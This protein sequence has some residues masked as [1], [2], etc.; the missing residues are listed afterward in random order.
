[1]QAIESW[2]RDLGFSEEL[3]LIC[4][5]LRLQSYKSIAVG[6]IFQ[7]LNQTDS[8]EILSEWTEHGLCQRLTQLSRAYHQ[9]EGIQNSYPALL[10]HANVKNQF[11]GQ[12][13]E[14]YLLAMIT[15]PLTFVQ[16]QKKQFW[17]R[18]LRLWVFI[19]ALL[20]GQQ[21]HSYLDKNLRIVARY[22]LIRPSYDINRWDVIDQLQQA[23]HAKLQGIQSDFD[24]FSDALGHAAQQLEAYT[25]ERSEGSFLRAIARIATGEVDSIRKSGE[26][27]FTSYISLPHAKDCRSRFYKR[28]HSIC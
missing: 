25:P 3:E 2:A 1:M 5:T 6:T 24:L 13:E 17:R 10:P 11:Q 27:E 23:T 14:L 26:P 22:L 20:R 8:K 9:S 16:D 21:F 18:K 12:L 15:N 28:T 19:Q 4:R 7:E